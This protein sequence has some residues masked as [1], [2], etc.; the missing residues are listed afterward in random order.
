MR[1]VNGVMAQVPV[2][3]AYGVTGTRWYPEGLHD[4]DIA[5]DIQYIE[6]TQ[7]G[8]DVQMVCDMLRHELRRRIALRGR[9]P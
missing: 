2:E 4:H 8:F 6:G 1:I 5:H 3:R 7:S 9:Q